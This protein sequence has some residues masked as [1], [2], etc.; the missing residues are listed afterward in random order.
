V[1]PP[2]EMLI[3]VFSSPGDFVST[4]NS[5]IP[6]DRLTL[7]PPALRSTSFAHHDQHSPKSTPE[8]KIFCPLRT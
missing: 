1:V 8:M 2:L 7:P 6:C 3:G 5:E 4:T